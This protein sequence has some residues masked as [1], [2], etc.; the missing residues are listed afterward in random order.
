MNNLFQQTAWLYDVDTAD[1]ASHDIGFLTHFTR[2][3]DISRHADVLELACGTGRV[4]IALAQAGRRV[5]GLDLSREMLSVFQAKLSRVDEPVA[6]RITMKH[7]N[8]ADFSLEDRFDTIIVP[9][10]GF[11]ALTTMEEAQSSLAAI[12]RHLR[13]KG[14]V[15]IDLFSSYEHPDDS[16]L[17]DHVDWIRRI[18]GSGQ[19][20]T[21]TRNGLHIDRASQILY[22]EVR[23]HILDESG[24]DQVLRDNFA[25]RYW[26]RYQF[27]VLLAAAGFEIL[28]EFGNYDYRPIGGG[29][30]FIFVARPGAGPR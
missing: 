23:F 11:Q 18:P 20:I 30:E 14:R 21:R 15:V 2:T 19:T 10:R 4:S 26:F 3:E 13:P 8:M 28:Q 22:S 7:A 27:E 9:F 6:S 1:L 29:P 24:K 16:F 17:G 12:R 5:T 25:L